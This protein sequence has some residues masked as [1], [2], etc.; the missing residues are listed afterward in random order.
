[1]QTVEFKAG[2]TIIA[3]GEAG[4]T[5]FL[6]ISGLVEVSISSAGHTKSVGTLAAGDVWRDEPDRLGAALG[7]GKGSD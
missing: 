7:H 1:M 5:A 4:E 2:E 6:M 3:E